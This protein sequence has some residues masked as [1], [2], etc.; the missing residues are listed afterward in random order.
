[1]FPGAWSQHSFL[2]AAAVAAQASSGQGPHLWSGYCDTPEGARTP[3]EGY[4]E[5]VAPPPLEFPHVYS[6]NS[7]K[8]TNGVREPTS[9]FSHQWRNPMQKSISV[10]VS[11]VSSRMRSFM[12]ERLARCPSELELEGPVQRLGALWELDRAPDVVV[13][14]KRKVTADDLELTLGNSKM[15]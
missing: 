9:T 8:W 5:S 7:G 3:V 14:A 12:G 1:M 13:G 15:L 2:A 4:S 10:P 11:P 6:P